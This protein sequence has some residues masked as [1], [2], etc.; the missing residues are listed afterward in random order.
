VAIRCEG[1]KS[2]TALD[3]GKLADGRIKNFEDIFCSK[4]L[5]IPRAFAMLKRPSDSSIY[6]LTDEDKGKV[7][8][9]CARGTEGK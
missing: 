4:A 6:V 7:W 8:R 5:T 1:G 3:R 9:L 2:T